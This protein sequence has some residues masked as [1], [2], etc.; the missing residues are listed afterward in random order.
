MAQQFSSKAIIMQIRTFGHKYGHMKSIVI[1]L[2]ASPL[3]PKWYKALWDRISYSRKQQW[4]WRKQGTESKLVPKQRYYDS[5]P[6]YP[7]PPP[8][9]SLHLTIQMSKVTK[10]AVSEIQAHGLNAYDNEVHLFYHLQATDVIAKGNH[11]QPT[12]WLPNVTWTS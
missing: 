5:K 10:I 6:S 3:G 12:D 11:T 4:R 9:D 2:P 1:R 7:M 8:P